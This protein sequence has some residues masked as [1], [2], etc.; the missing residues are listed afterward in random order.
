MRVSAEH[1]ANTSNP[2]KDQQHN[3]FAQQ[4]RNVECTVKMFQ[5]WHHD[6][7]TE[8]EHYRNDKESLLSRKM[9]EN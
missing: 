4:F 2:C 1:S 6:Q 5:G 7:Y 3:N 9:T 8:P